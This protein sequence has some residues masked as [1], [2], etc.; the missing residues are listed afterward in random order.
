M[1]SMS[2]Q[3]GPSGTSSMLLRVSGGMILDSTWRQRQC[4]LKSLLIGTIP[5]AKRKSVT[6]Q[7][8]TGLFLVHETLR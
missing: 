5:V 7:T 8:I 1:T 3:C 2:G 4:V 6:T